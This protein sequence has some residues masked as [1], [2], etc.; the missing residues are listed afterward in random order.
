M[1]VFPSNFP[2]FSTCSVSAQ[3]SQLLLA[4]SSQTG[5]LPPDWAKTS[6][7]HKARNTTEVSQTVLKANFS[8]Y[9]GSGKVSTLL[10]AQPEFL[11]A[12][13]GCCAKEEHLTWVPAPAYSFPP[14]AS[15]GSSLKGFDLWDKQNFTQADKSELLSA[16][17]VQLTPS[18]LE[19]MTRVGSDWREQS[20]LCCVSWAESHKSKTLFLEHLGLGDVFQQRCWCWMRQIRLQKVELSLSKERGQLATQPTGTFSE[21]FSVPA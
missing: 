3:L 9:R 15:S 16:E 5:A 11:Q 1:D 17:T 6:A 8:L 14:R 10:R 20:V 21:S 4:E 7:Q 19:D 18:S 2:C 13:Q 12:G